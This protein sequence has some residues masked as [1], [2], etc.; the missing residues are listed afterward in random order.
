MTCKAKALWWRRL[1]ILLA[2]VVIASSASL[3]HVTIASAAGAA[4]A[5]RGF[6]P[7]AI[8]HELEY[9]RA[10]STLPNATDAMRFEWGV[11]SVVHRM[12]QA[13]DYRTAVYMRDQ[14]AADGWDAKIVTYV[15]P[16]AWP[17][18]Q[19]LTI[20][21]P[22][23]R[24]VDLY[25][26]GIAQDPWSQRHAEIGKP[27]SGYSVDGDVNGPLIYAGH[28]SESDFETLAKMH[29]S[30]KGA[31][32]IAAMGGGG[33]VSKGKRAAQLGARALLIYPEPGYDPYYPQFRSAK[34]YP[35]GPARPIGA[36]M[37]NTLTISDAGGDPTA[38]GI[39]IPGAKHKPFSAL[40]VP[41]IPVM[42]VTPL[43]AQ[44]LDQYL[45]GPA[46]P[47]GWTSKIASHIHIGGMERVH[48]IIKSRRFFGPMWNVIAT[49]KGEVAPD[50]MVIVGGHRDAWTWGAID[51]GSGSVA[52]LQ[53]GEDFGKLRKAGWRPYRTIV[54][55][56]WDGE[57]LNDFGSS[58]WVD[59]YKE[60]LLRKCLA[61]VNTDEVANGP[62]YIPSASDDLFDLLQS[63]ADGAIAPNGKT[64]SAYWAKQDPKRAIT[65]MGTGSDHESFQFHLNIPSLSI[66]YGGVFGTYH[67]GY[68]DIASL[69]IL[70]PGMRYADAAARLYNL[71]TLRLADAPYPDIQ[72]HL[73]ALAMQRR[74]S[75]FANGRGDESVRR[76]V[77]RTLQP[78]VDK[79]ARL[80]ASVDE[81]ADQ[82][83]ATGNLFAL[84]N[85]R[86]GMIQIRSAFYSASGVPGDP[87]QRSILYNSDDTISTLPSL[88]T[89]LDP[90][91]G[92]AA[93]DQLVAA[94]HKLPPLLIVSR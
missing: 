21:A 73:D 85:M 17:T 13:T 81:A 66:Y 31:I 28:G 65:A 7:V 9:E 56:S 35:L 41:S 46:A 84:A 64:L 15:V 54:I 1:P 78:L 75:A 20:T 3:A 12:G 92:K 30:I 47:K 37:R 34:S 38:I 11:A 70:D 8:A 68:D 10:V 19:Q 91:R 53:M 50:E 14:L 82:A 22:V 40:D 76:N 16:I 51:P 83:V 5:L 80:S 89:T 25:E 58:I 44:Q 33:S 48:L 90:K 42:T 43:V 52:M 94:F 24:E 18:Q 32:V 60:Q 72:L 59:Q 61:Y 2:A 62:T 29:V 4:P 69:K 39:P 45:G 77:V 87:Y 55:G 63:V 71:I 23:Q 27:Y 36:A 79:F 26:P 49:M 74:L 6:P 57:E 67:S 88:E 86:A 93:L